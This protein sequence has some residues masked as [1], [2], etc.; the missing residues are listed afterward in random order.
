MHI[1]QSDFQQRRPSPEYRDAAQLLGCLPGIL[2][3]WVCSPALHKPAV[4]VHTYDPSTQ[5]ADAEG[6][7]DQ[8]HP[9]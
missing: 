6:P 8:N 2:K 7:G 5:E 9:P 3:A 1:Q 4:V